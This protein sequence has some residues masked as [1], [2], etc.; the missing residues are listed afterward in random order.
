[1]CVS[2]PYVR[3]AIRKEKDMQFHGTHIDVRSRPMSD[4]IVEFAF[5]L[6]AD[7]DNA[8]MNHV[9]RIEVKAVSMIDAINVAQDILVVEKANTFQGFL[10][11][12]QA[13]EN[14]TAEQIKNEQQDIMRAWILDDPTAIQVFTKDSIDML[15]NVTEQSVME[16]MENISD[17]VEEFLKEQ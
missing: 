14:V 2:L 12:E 8:D 3:H 16:N 7:A 15:R 11:S 13:A 1:M 17:E 6:D 10:E 4:Y 9:Y 5:I